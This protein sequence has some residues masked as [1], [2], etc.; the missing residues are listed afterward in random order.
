MKKRIKRILSLMMLSFLLITAMIPSVA[1]SLDATMAEE[2]KNSIEQDKKEVEDSIKE[3][4]QVKGDTEVYVKKLDS[5]LSDITEELSKIETKMDEKQGEIEKTGTELEQARIDEKNQYESMKLRIQYMYEKG[6]TSYLDLLFSSENIGELLNR[7]EYISQISEYDRKMLISY[8]ETKDSIAKKEAQQ[9]EDYANLEVLQGAETSKKSSVETLVS[10]K[11]KE[12]E[13]Y[14]ED[15][16]VAEDQVEQYQKDLKD[17]EDRI[18][19]IEDEIKKKEAAAEASRKAAEESRK[20]AE[21]SR[22][23]A[24]ESSRVAESLKA[25]E[26]SAKAAS[27]EASRE[28]AKATE[29]PGGSTEETTK[30]ETTKKET[31]KAETTK[32]PESPGPSE[33]TAPPSSTSLIWPC[34]SSKRVTSEFGGRDAPIAGASSNHQGMDIGAPTG[35]NIIAAASGEVVISTYSYSAGN[36]IMI[37]H[38]NGLMTVYMHCSQLLVSEGASVKQGDVIAKVGSTGYSTGPHL[39]FGVRVNGVYVNPRNYV[40]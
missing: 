17:Q 25:D 39:H 26:E 28:A 2:E 23:A 33:N 30:L 11:T 27:E 9:K 1:S 13:Q 22:K 35:T 37:S 8:Q 6:D 12:L 20:A 4:N 21:E 19:K 3:L 40:N 16:S 24:E 5:K 38:G 34:P 14:E 32:A 36:Y 7:A 31:T 10:E 18:R 15:I 29:G